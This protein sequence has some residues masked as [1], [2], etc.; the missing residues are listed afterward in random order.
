[1]GLLPEGAS[2]YDSANI[3]LVHHLYAALRARCTSRTS[4]TWCRTMKW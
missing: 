1:M 3:T 2:L 4:T